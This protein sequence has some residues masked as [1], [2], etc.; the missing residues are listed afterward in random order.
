MTPLRGPTLPEAQKASI[1]ERELDSRLQTIDSP[2]FKRLSAA[3]TL[4]LADRD[5][6]W[7][8]ETGAGAYSVTLPPAPLASGV[9]Y[10]IKRIGTNTITL[11]GD[12]AETVDGSATLALGT[13]YDA[14]TIRS[15]GTE[16]WTV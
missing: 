6:V 8:C 9:S 12:G 3:Y 2:E 5:F 16:W 10:T 15:D 14:V 4:T 11:D 13:Q 7:L 1:N